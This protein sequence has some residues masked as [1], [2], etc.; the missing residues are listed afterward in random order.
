MAFKLFKRKNYADVI[1]RGGKIYTFDPDYPQADAL[2]V[3]DGRVMLAGDAEEVAALQGPDTRFIELDGGFAVPGFIDCFGMPVR[4]T[5]KNTYLALDTEMDEDA[6][7]NAVAA[8][9]AARPN[10]EFCLAVDIN[11]ELTKGPNISE[12]NDGWP[13]FRDRLSEAFPDKPVVLVASNGLNM[14]INETA[15][16]ITAERAEEMNVLTVTPA[17]VIDSVISTDYDLCIKQL[18]EVSEYYAKQGVTS[19]YASE[20]YSFFEKMYRDLLMD[21]F[22]ADQIRQRYYGSFQVRRRL[23]PQSVIYSAERK[24]TV[25]QE[26]AGKINFNTIEMRFSSD[27]EA[28]DCMEEEYIRMVSELAAD[29]GYNMRFIA[30]DK[31]AA[32]TALDIAGNLSS[33]NRKQTFAV[34]HKED[35]TEEEL[36]SI[37]TGDAVELAVGGPRAKREL[38]GEELVR[39]LSETAARSI[40]A[41]ALGTLEEGKWAD[42]AVFPSDPCAEGA[43]AQEANMTIVAGE[44]VYEKGADNAAGW[45]AKMAEAIG[46]NTAELFG[47][48]NG[49]SESEE[50]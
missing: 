1:I 36:G 7:I 37:Y 23:E 26:L 21:A 9:F 8:F 32:L 42:L 34:V 17:F 30:L 27:E 50:I 19:V 20:Q 31:N 24:R 40:G 41:Y 33:S 18:C 16:A 12:E 10:A 38:S 48:Q 2:A 35:F 29:K 11:E 44:T 25:C 6:I 39:D 14:Q 49:E 45:A 47:E 3:K 43:R 15:R 22:Q 4:E 5:L 28:P 46:V 13:T